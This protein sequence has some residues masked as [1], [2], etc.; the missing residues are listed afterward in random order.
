MKSMKDMSIKEMESIHGRRDK[1]FFRNASIKY[2]IAI[3]TGVTM[4]I[5]M[6]TLAVLMLTFYN[7]AI[8][9]RSNRQTE[10][11]IRI[12]SERIATVVDNGAV[13]ANHLT[14]E[15]S[16]LYN[17]RDIKLVTRNSKL[18]GTLNSARIV[19]MGIDSII[20]TDC[21][22]TF[23]STDP[24]AVNHTEEIYELIEKTELHNNNGQPVLLDIKDAI[25]LDGEGTVTLAK[26]VINVTSGTPLGYL[27]INID[28]E[29]L[30]E[31]AWSEISFYLL[32]DMTG[33]S[34]QGD[35]SE[36]L[37]QDKDKLE[38]I[39]Y[40][41]DDLIRYSG[42]SWV[43]KRTVLEPYGWTVIGITNLN[44][45]NVTGSEFFLILLIAGGIG[46]LLL[47]ITVFATATLVTRPLTRLH[48]GAEKIAE[49]DMSV[50]F[51]FNT[52]DEI[53][54]LGR[55]FNYMTQRN[56]EL[57]IAVDEEARK[58]R[59]YEL[60]L[61]Q[62]QVKPHFLYNTLDIIIM[63]IE[64][65]RSAEAKR[66]T[67]KLANYY[68]NSLSGSDETVTVGRECEIVADYLELQRMRYGNNLRFKIE[69]DEEAQ[70]AHIPK[71]TFQPLV[72][73]AIYHGLK[74]KEGLGS[75]NIS[76][77]V[78]DWTVIIRIE[79]TGI[80]M[81]EEAMN[82]L[83]A[84]LDARIKDGESE[85]HFGVYSADHRLKLYFGEDYGLSFESEYGKGTVVTIKIPYT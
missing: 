28:R 3:I 59:E 19:Y 77:H 74:L 5:P 37:L 50:R 46:F 39:Y 20:F 4:L 53:G 6:V 25:D 36:G 60:A 75:I 44:R 11:N 63:L 32:Y 2:K 24:S 8:L 66:V 64:M 58:K 38:E 30:V 45:F 14:I 47:A 1:G 76:G 82:D 78:E 41:S 13:C 34:I 80:G 49:G 70:K 54:M 73:N 40:G 12:M 83:R 67:Q 21:E 51:H 26:R 10:E 81:D 69:V 56:T 43:I 65:N 35:Y 7:R 55:I 22:E 15:L 18:L 52:R 16:D 68:K 85:G 71:M 62:E 48:D 27:L 33:D 23:I 84:R 57:L 61:I 9:E 42:E 79:D 31:S 29:K 17:N 72:E